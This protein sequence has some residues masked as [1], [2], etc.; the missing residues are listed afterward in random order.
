MNTN[1]TDTHLWFEAYFKD[2]FSCN[3]QLDALQYMHESEYVHADVK[4]A[5]ILQGYHNGKDV[6]NQVCWL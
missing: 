6:P 4:A 3:Q 2:I 1:Y 5:N